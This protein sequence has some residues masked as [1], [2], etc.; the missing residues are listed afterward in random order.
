MK[1]LV[2]SSLMLCALSPLPVFAAEQIP[3]A[4]I[5]LDAAALSHNDLVVSPARA[6][7]VYPTFAVVTQVVADPTRLVHLHPAGSGKV[8]AVLVQPGARVKQGQAL[9]RYQ[10]HTLHAA[11]LQD[12][13]ARAALSAALAARWDAAQAVQRAQ[14][15]VGQSVSV[16]ELRRR[17]D[18]L[19]QAEASVRM[20]QADVDTLGHRFNEEFNSVSEQSA[21]QNQTEVST[22]IAPMDGVVQALDTS[23]AADLSATQDVMTVAD[24]SSVWLVSEILPEQ[25]HLIA[26]G[27]RQTTAAGAQAVVSR[28]DTVEGMAN[29]LT[30]LLRVISH[31]SDPTGALVPGMV[32]NATLTEKNG[33]EGLIVPSQA[34]QTINGRSVVFVRRD[35]THYRPVEVDVALDNGEQAV[36]HA[37]LKEGEP[38]V[39][40]GSFVLRSVLELAGM[41][42]D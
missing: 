5:V 36:I 35:A 24:L 16:A 11:R 2:L 28:I 19:A 7:M 38:V 33:V 6:G 9:L 40:A 12:T 20:H 1:K 34:V 18:T 3:P 21:R 14:Q 4:D 30:G 25:A 23:V 37:G 27:G 31:V 42:A 26:P 41:D 29:P 13:Q 10:D 22:L 17:Q 39:G 8:L 32:F 15:L